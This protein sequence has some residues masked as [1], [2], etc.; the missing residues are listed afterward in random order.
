MGWAASPMARRQRSATSFMEVSKVGEDHTR[1]V[2]RYQPELF[3]TMVLM[4][5]YLRRWL[6]RQRTKDTEHLKQM[7]ESPVDQ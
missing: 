3:G 7:L 6:S 2:S 4:R 5:P 1:L